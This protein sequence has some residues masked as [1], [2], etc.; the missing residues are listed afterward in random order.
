MPYSGFEG[1]QYKSVINNASYNDYVRKHNPAILY[2]SVTN[3]ENR[4]SQIKNFTMLYKD[5]EN[6][7]SPPEVS[8]KRSL[9][10]VLTSYLGPSTMDVYHTGEPPKLISFSALTC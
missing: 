4:L 8:K 10:P 9:G 6:D 5:L 7:V 1:Y 3:S 2:D